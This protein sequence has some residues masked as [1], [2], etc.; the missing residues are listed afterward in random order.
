MKA[1]LF[2]CSGNSDRSPAAQYLAQEYIEANNL[3]IEVRSRGTNVRGR[4]MP[5]VLLMIAIP[6]TRSHTPTP[7]DRETIEWA[8]LILTMNRQH[9]EI[10]TTMVAGATDKTHCFYEYAEGTTK[11]VADPADHGQEDYEDFLEEM[12]RL[13]ELSINK[14]V[15]P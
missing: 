13:V 6:A 2:V 14:F 11:A 10:V 15:T 7:L 9:K 8:D 4:S 12:K 1:L 3:D 5:G